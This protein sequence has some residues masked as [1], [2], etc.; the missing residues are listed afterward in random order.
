MEDKCFLYCVKCHKKLLVRL[1]NGLFHLA[2]GN[3][4]L[5]DGTLVEGK[6]KI[7]LLIFGSV[8]IKCYSKVC[9]A[10]NVFNFFPNTPVD[11][12]EQV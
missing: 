6:P 1:P 5:P 2:Y 8:R 9:E 12:V 11:F 7:D 3:I 10:W 4:R